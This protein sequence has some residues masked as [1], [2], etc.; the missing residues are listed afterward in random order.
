M[1][2]YI[3][4]NHNV[5]ES[6]GRH[7]TLD[8]HCHTNGRVAPLHLDPKVGHHHH[9]NEESQSPS[10]AVLLHQCCKMFTAG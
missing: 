3:D 8:H 7:L 1:Y 4:Y 10:R 6:L 9:G 2:N 5:A